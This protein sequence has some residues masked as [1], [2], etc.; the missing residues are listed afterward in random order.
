MEIYKIARLSSQF[1]FN[2]N[3]KN[4]NILAFLLVKCKRKFFKRNIMLNITKYI[5]FSFQ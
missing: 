1:S 4:I 5:F 2:N 3:K